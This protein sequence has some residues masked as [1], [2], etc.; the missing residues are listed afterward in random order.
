MTRGFVVVIYWGRSLLMFLEP[1]SKC[2]CWLSNVFFITIYP[3]TFVS[4]YD[5]TFLKDRLLSFGTHKE[6]FDGKFSFKVHLYPIFSTWSFDAFTEPFVIWNHHVYI[7]V[8]LVVM[9][10]M[11]VITS[12]LVL[13]GC[14]ALDLHYVQGPCW[15]LAPFKSLEEMLFFL[16]QQL[17]A[18]PDGFWSMIEGAHHTVFWWYCVVAVPLQVQVCMVRLPVNWFTEFAIFLRCY[19]CCL[20]LKFKF[21]FFLRKS[22]KL[23]ENKQN[24]KH[25]CI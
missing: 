17:W 10:S 6:V 5:S 16:L 8:V 24:E 13:G 20:W 18:R 7:L 22:T 12:I 19:I 15:V 9:S 21:W 11:F 2:S 4:V 23:H 3:I 14:L 1:L 25:P